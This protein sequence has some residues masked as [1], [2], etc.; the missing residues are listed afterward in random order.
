MLHY[1]D[2]KTEVK[3]VKWAAQGYSEEVAESAFNAFSTLCITSDLIQAKVPS[4]FTTQNLPRRGC[5][6]Q[7]TDNPETS[8]GFT[9]LLNDIGK[10]I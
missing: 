3:A 6:V 8:L 1:R 10:V 2:D 4:G 7:G 5:V 9:N